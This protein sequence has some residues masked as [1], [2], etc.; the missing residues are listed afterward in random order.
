M[1]YYNYQQ[2]LIYRHLNQDKGWI[3][4]EEHCRKFIIKALD[5][6]KPRKVTVYGSGWLL[7]LP[8]AEMIERVEC[9]SLVDIIHPPEVITQTAGFKNIQIVED[10]VTGGLIEEV[11]KKAGNRTFINRLS[12]L[13]GISV[14][15]YQPVDDPG[16]AISLNILTQ[17][18]SLPEKLLR[19]KSRVN[20]ESFLNFRK[21]I[22]QQHIRFLEKHNSVIIS[23]LAEIY[24]K[25]GGESIQN[26][27]VLAELPTGKIREEWIW[28]FDLAGK[29]YNLKKSVFKV[30]GIML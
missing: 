12:S 30:V 7:D 6:Y 9:I 29:D 17:L 3:S 20:E 24:M 15:E 4:H 27:T 19:K 2:G 18:E 26:D 25:E 13:N 16:L 28:D 14:S 8:V 10:D 21:E 1:G 22:Q 11:W 5:F 23:D